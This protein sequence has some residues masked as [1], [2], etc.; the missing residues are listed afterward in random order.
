MFHQL[1]SL[2][3]KIITVFV[4]ELS[5]PQSLSFHVMDIE[6]TVVK[7]KNFFPVKVTMVCVC[8]HMLSGLHRGYQGNVSTIF[9]SGQSYHH[10]L[11]QI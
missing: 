8:V 10:Q 7:F 9:H 11:K 4:R 6:V 5:D 1:F 3:Q 2:G